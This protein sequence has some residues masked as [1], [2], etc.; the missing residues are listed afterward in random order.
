MADEVDSRGIEAALADLWLANREEALARAA[1]IEDAAAALAT[2]G[3]DEETRVAA[4]S[5]AHKLRGSVGMY[6]FARAGELAGEAEDLL[7]APGRIAPELTPRLSALAL[8]IATEL[9]GAPRPA[10]APAASGHPAALAL[11]LDRDLAT[12]LTDSAPESALALEAAGLEAA[13]DLLGAGD[14]RFALVDAA[15]MSTGAF[16]EVRAAANGTPLVA[17]GDG[18]SLAARVE[19]TRHGALALLDRDSSPSAIL[20]SAKRVADR[21]RPRTATILA[22]DDDPAVLAALRAMLEPRGFRVEGAQ[23]PEEFW[24]RL[25]SVSPD[26]ALVDLDMPGVNGIELTAAIRADSRWAGLPLL[27]L[28][29]YREPELIRSCFAAGIDDYLTKPIVEDELA[30]RLR[31]RLERDRVQVAA[32]GRDQLTGVRVRQS[33]LR[34]A[35]SL[36]GEPGTAPL[37]VGLVDVDD[38]AALNDAEGFGAGD[39]ALRS[40]AEVLLAAFPDGVVGRWDGDEF[41]V[42]APACPPDRA[43]GLLSEAIAGANRAASAGVAAAETAPGLFEAVAAA[44]EAR[45]TAKRAGGREVRVAAI[46][47]D[48]ADSPDVVLVEDDHSVAD[49][50]ALALGNAG[51]RISRIDSGDAAVAAL[52]GT[53]PALRPRAVVLDW[54]LPGLDGLSV[55]RA[56]AADGTLDRVRVIMLTARGGEAEMLKALELGAADYV[57]KPFSVPVL[58]E[59]VKRAVRR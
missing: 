40:I 25:A 23:S 57:S 43:A 53:A 9:E 52:A 59:R 28:T 10:S 35:R 42:V 4:R 26:A 37:A 5:A 24:D 33:A 7:A 3:L 58:V 13:A 11:G 56:L 44:G 41:L 48:A 32:A 29:A 18:G 16:A 47:P 36:A 46:D 19:A 34:A 2:G 22:V 50:V 38:L 51:L 20:D 17:V 8:A 1:L 27:M 6:G 12:A 45:A 30:G 31:N 39:E 14:L 49:V 15:A 54:D 21:A 55:L